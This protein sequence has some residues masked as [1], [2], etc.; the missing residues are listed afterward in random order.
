[1]STKQLTED[2][3]DETYTPKGNIF[4]DDEGFK[5]YETYGEELEYVLETSRKSPNTVW[6][7]LEGDEGTYYVPGVH[8]VNRIG[9]LI[10]ENPWESEDIEV[11]EDEF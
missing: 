4:H 3:F 5:M 2:Q 10:T 11:K 7:I 8:T 1:M 9:Y 6:T